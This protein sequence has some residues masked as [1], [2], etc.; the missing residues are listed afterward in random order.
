MLSLSGGYGHHFGH[1][2]YG[3][4]VLSCYSFNYLKFSDT[5]GKFLGLF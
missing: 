1:Y 5:A 4:L 3:G 2:G